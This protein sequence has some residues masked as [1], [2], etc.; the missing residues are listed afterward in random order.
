[1]SN[2]FDQDESQA[3]PNTEDGSVTPSSEG[4]TG[5]PLPSDAPNGDASQGET[6]NSE[7][8]YPF[9]EDATEPIALGQA[10]PEGSTEAPEAQD[11]SGESG[12]HGS[13]EYRVF[14]QNKSPKGAFMSSAP[15][16]E[17]AG[18]TERPHR[19]VSKGVI[20]VA[21]SAVV[22][23]AAVSGGVSY[24]IARNSSTNSQAPV[25][26]QVTG[27]E[28]SNTISSSSGS[29]T[30]ILNKVEPAIVDVIARG[31]TNAGSGFFGGGTQSFE[32]EGTGMIMTSNGYVVTNNHVIAGASTVNVTLFNSSKSYPA[33]V[34]G[35]DPTSDVAV[36]QI[37]G[38]SNLPTVTFGDSSKV[39][40]G[41]SVIAIGNA[42]GLSGSPTVTEGIISALG[43]T[44]TAQG[45]TGTTETLH[46]LLQTD[47]PINPGNSGGP[48][49]NASGYV[50][51]MN[52]AA[53]SGSSGSSSAQNIGFAEPI[54]SV[55]SIVKSIEA[56]PTSSI[57]KG[58][59][60]SGH[61]FLG[62]GVQNLTAALAQQLG[63]NSN[64]TGVLVDNVVTGSPADQ[65]G[66]T[67]GD[68]ITG[69]GGSTV[70]DLNQLISAID[71]HQPGA[72]VQV[73]WVD[74][75]TGNN[76]ATVTL[77]SSPSA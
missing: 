64:Q 39:K 46:N 59:T 71:S 19:S 38:V 73:T 16:F 34:I 22:I 7:W 26:K 65:A 15:G 63:Y 66:I 33:R 3:Q 69:I 37:Q 21:A 20:G 28:T 52:T 50:I 58:A 10:T 23:A 31:T 24:L 12:S 2:E 13:R 53:A 74:P 61:A 54:D 4:T 43:R 75:N 5:H 32:S 25:I 27:S 51:G 62:V 57:G 77:A 55:L 9:A 41:D 36:L 56:H 68:V 18:A 17:D 60:T 70:T 8:V 47:A 40:V 6:S 45:D 48:L 49:V 67:S 14:A 1:M 76:S 30:G 35:T 29:I 11:G 72:S 44:I 42:L